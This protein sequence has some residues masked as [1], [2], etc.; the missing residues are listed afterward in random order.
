MSKLTRVKDSVLSTAL[1]EELFPVPI[2]ELSKTEDNTAVLNKY[3]EMS[4]LKGLTVFIPQ[5]RWPVY[6]T[7]EL[8]GVIIIPLSCASLRVR[9][10]KETHR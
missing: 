6:G 8:G 2:S 4:R 1:W 10:T 5:G 7:L 9:I 3:L